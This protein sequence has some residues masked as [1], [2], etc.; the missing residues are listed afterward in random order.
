M[1]AYHH[2]EPVLNGAA[3]IFSY[4]TKPEDWYFKQLIPGKRKYIT[5]KIQGATTLEEARVLFATAMV[6]ASKQSSVDIKPQKK[7]SSKVTILQAVDDWL[8]RQGE[9]CEAGVIEPSTLESKRITLQ[10][11]LVRYFN[12]EGIEYCD[13]IKPDSLER[14]P[15]YRKGAS[16]LTIKKDL[17]RIKEWI[18]N[19]CIKY[20]LV[21]N[22]VVLERNLTPDVR[23]RQDELTANP[24]INPE[25]WL[26]INRWIR[27]WVKDGDNWTNDRIKCWRTNFWTFTMTLKNSGCRPCELRNLQWRDVTFENIGRETSRGTVEDFWVAHLY[28]RRTKT[29]VP[30]TVPTDKNV[31]RRLLYW[32]AFLNAWWVRRGWN[33]Q[34]QP[35]DYVFG[36]AANE[37][38]PYHYSNYDKMWRDNIM[39]ELFGKGL[40]KG[41]Q[42]SDRRYTLYS[43]RSTYIESQLIK[44]KL[45][46]YDLARVCGHSIAVLERHYSRMDIKSKTREI[47]HIDYGRKESL[48]IKPALEM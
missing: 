21:S 5:K 2:K 13:Q 4:V 3:S 37:C 36:N 39:T 14:Y 16:K 43:C 31:A 19:H 11:H 35:T 20:K 7:R 26:V 47:T 41:N 45:S 1:P 17:G 15:L 29:T 9:R 34:V 48:K 46:I 8:T 25:D 33:R 27:D 23:V 44:G 22:D 24:S 40:L 10:L 32:K 18:E 42:F 30:R 6:E 28:I 38:R 12:A